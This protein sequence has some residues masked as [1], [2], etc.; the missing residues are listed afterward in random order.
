[1]KTVFKIKKT[2]TQ[3]ERDRELREGVKEGIRELKAISSRLQ[4]RLK[5]LKNAT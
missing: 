2:R 4:K 5:V 1:M 3:L